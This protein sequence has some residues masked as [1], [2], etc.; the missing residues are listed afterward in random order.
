MSQ[1]LFACN[2]G[3][4]NAL[5]SKKI[6]RTLFF[7]P[8]PEN[9]SSI[10]TGPKAKR[11]K[12]SPEEENEVKSFIHS[13]TSAFRPVSNGIDRKRVNELSKNLENFSE[14]QKAEN[15]VSK[16]EEHS[17]NETGNSYSPKQKI[18]LERQ[19]Q[20]ELLKEQSSFDLQDERWK[21]IERE[22]EKAFSNCH[23]NRNISK[24]FPDFVN[25]SSSPI[26]RT[27]LIEQSSVGIQASLID[28]VSPLKPLSYN[29]NKCKSPGQVP[30]QPL[31]GTHRASMMQTELIPFQQSLA[32]KIS[33]SKSPS[34]TVVLASS[35]PFVV[36]VPSRGPGVVWNSNL[37]Q[38]TQSPQAV[39]LSAPGY[40]LSSNSQTHQPPTSTQPTIQSAIKKQSVIDPSVPNTSHCSMPAFQPKPITVITQ[41]T[42][43]VK[44][45]AVN[46]VTVSAETPSGVGVLLSGLPRRLSLPIHG[47]ATSVQ[48]LM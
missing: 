4:P 36:P 48:N 13:S 24:K 42:P 9:D 31:E 20:K 30:V 47:Q 46:P 8:M 14:A 25:Q 27:Q 23:P 43:T 5:E 10:H 2:H 29:H 28:T 7:S 44:P 32:N 17:E 11:L 21:R 18:Y 41:L 15:D 16:Q 37:S 35:A 38:P 6:R 33:P 22:L 1:L 19:K 12:G 34:D 39:I 40:N 45:S 26:P 3:L